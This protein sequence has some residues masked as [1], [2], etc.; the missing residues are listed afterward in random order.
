MYKK[1]F[2]F[3]GQTLD[4]SL[5]VIVSYDRRMRTD[6]LCITKGDFKGSIMQSWDDW[7]PV[8][9][10]TLNIVNNSEDNPYPICVIDCKDTLE[11]FFYLCEYF[12]QY[13]KNMSLTL[14]YDLLD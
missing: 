13:D 10:P 2:T 9:V 14:I 7:N 12:T 3:L 8:G 5:D 1:T 11:A 6:V 4:V